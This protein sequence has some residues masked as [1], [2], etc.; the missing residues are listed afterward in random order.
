MIEAA[1]TANSMK[2]IDAQVHL[3]RA[4]T[5]DRPWPADRAEGAHGPSLEAEQMLAM[6]NEAGVA[7]AVIVLP[8]WEGDR[9]DCALDAAT[10]FPDRFAIM[11]RLAI[12][13]PS[14]RERVA[15]WKKQAGMLGMRFTFHGAQHKQWLA[16]GTAD[17]LWSQ[18]QAHGVPLMVNVPGSVRAM[19][20]V[21]EQHPGLRLTIDHLACAANKKDEEAHS[22]I[23]DLIR[24]ARHP[25][26]SVKASAVARYT[27]ESYPYPNTQ[28]KLRRIFD[29]YG[30]QRFF[31][32]SDISR[33]PGT[34]RQAITL[35]TQELNWLSPQDQEWVMG[36]GLCEWLGWAY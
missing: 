22:E 7:R 1:A 4:N 2:V 34:Y 3:W 17:W 18:A 31:W 21:A 16:D 30:P 9:N 10:R 6:M 14:S 33:L 28:L 8:S 11:G 13:D 27:T 23:E 15:D 26:V 36:R 12:E 24:L 29:A 25:N 19:D 20:R 5:P 32:G 35:F